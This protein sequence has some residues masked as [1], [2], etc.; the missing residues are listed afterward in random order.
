LWVKEKGL[1]LHISTLHQCRLANTEPEKVFMEN[2][3]K[4][5]TIVHGPYFA[6]RTEELAELVGKMKKA[7]LDKNPTLRNPLA[8]M[9]TSLPRLNMCGTGVVNR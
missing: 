7:I 3:F 4:Y 9:G 5:G 1:F 8:S 2:P 6:D